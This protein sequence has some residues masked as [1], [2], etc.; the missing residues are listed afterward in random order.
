VQGSL[1]KILVVRKQKVVFQIIQKIMQKFRCLH[2]RVWLIL[3][4]LSM[5][6]HFLKAEILI[7]GIMPSN[8][9]QTAVTLQATVPASPNSTSV[10]FN[11]G[12]SLANLTQTTLAQNIL[13]TNSDVV[14]SRF[15]S[16]LQCATTYYYTVNALNAAI[17]SVSQVNSF[18]TIPCIESDAVIETISASNITLSSAQLNGSI[19][20]DHTY[21]EILF[22][23]EYG[24]TTDYGVV[25]ERGPFNGSLT[26]KRT[27][28]SKQNNFVCGTTYHYRL[29]GNFQEDANSP[30]VTKYGNDVS[31]ETLPCNTIDVH[32]VTPIVA[33]NDTVRLQ[34]S[35]Q[36]SKAQEVEVYFSWGLTT[37]LDNSSTPITI[38]DSIGTF[39]HELKGLL[40]D[41][42]YFYSF[43]VA[44]VATDD[45]NSFFTHACEAAPVVVTLGAA[46]ISGSAV[47]LIANVAPNDAITSVYFEWGLSDFY[48]D[49]TASVDIS[50]G[51]TKKPVE[52]V[53]ENLSCDT[54]YFYRA[55]ASNINGEIGGEGKSFKTE[56]CNPSNPGEGPGPSIDPNFQRVF[57]GGQFG[58]ALDRSGSLITW[59][60]NEFGQLGGEVNDFR[61]IDGVQSSLFGENQDIT[62]IVFNYIS[63]AAG[64]NHVLLLNKESDLATVVMSFGSNNNGQLG[65]ESDGAFAYVPDFVI[66]SGGTALGDVA[67]IAAGDE[68]SV[69]LT[70]NGEVF[71]W[72]DN[73]LGQLA[74]KVLNE[75]SEA[76]SVI[77]VS[78]AKAIASGSGFVIALLDNGKLKAWGQ[79]DRGQ[80]ANGSDANSF[81]VVNVDRAENIVDIVAGGK[82]ALALTEDASLIAWGANDSGQLGIGNNDDRKIISVVSYFT[83]NN[84]T[85]RQLAAGEKHTMAL[86]TDGT[87]YAWGS[88]NKGQLGVD[89]ESAFQLEPVIVVDDN[90]EP[91]SDIVNIAAGEDFSIAVNQSGQILTWGDNSVGQLNGVPS[92]ASVRDKL[93][94]KNKHATQ[95]SLNQQRI[96]V[97]TTSLIIEQG[98][99]GRVRIRLAS[100][101]QDST[102]VELSITE[103]DDGFVIDKGGQVF[104]DAAN[105]FTQKIVNIQASKEQAL[106]RKVLQIN[107]AG[108]ETITIDV[109]I[110]PVDKPKPKEQVVGANFVE[111]LIFLLLCII[112][113][114]FVDRNPRNYFT[115]LD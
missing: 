77:G 58:V 67:Q 62:R 12:L 23:F 51:F 17:E 26:S 27:V 114:S 1:H 79:N 56:S 42:E 14:I 73:K 32:S 69:A 57:A 30:S 101:P 31:F 95:I 59:G 48:T 8:I 61:F 66:K 33:A 84:L 83:D 113:R 97:D 100:D 108:A 36:V 70:N 76:I 47:K 60:N 54:T 115:S 9:G 19:E 37:D 87:V 7:S 81:D 43:V 2:S 50:G 68:H 82:H 74:S 80:L 46:D 3:F 112:C 86:L 35:V 72:G 41:T 6:I 18:T 22:G 106:G 93:T 11:Y 75:S 45:V 13:S 52:M 71:V 38:D 109:D 21:V 53:L 89:N 111:T 107:T 4:W 102:L 98:S 96:V 110:V 88:N 5:P 44:G 28:E 29:F 63:V 78:N 90:A 24:L 85:I 65:R 15:V 25:T 105:W 20:L 39:F 92:E 10:Y 103:G 34:A 94:L 55:V 99:V 40:C 49:S 16:G 91:L 104:F 64:K